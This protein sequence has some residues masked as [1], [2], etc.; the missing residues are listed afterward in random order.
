LQQAGR[1]NL[2][3]LNEVVEKLASGEELPL[4][5]KNH[6]LKGDLVGREECH[7][8]GDW[9]LIYRRDRNILVLTLLRSG[10]HSQLFGE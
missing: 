9:L 4:Q 2:A 1:Y 3:K 7:I 6:P 8:Q 10:T 5:F